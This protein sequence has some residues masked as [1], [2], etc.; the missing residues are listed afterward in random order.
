MNCNGSLSVTKP[1]ILTFS[2]CQSFINLSLLFEVRFNETPALTSGN[3][4]WASVLPSY[5]SVDVV[6]KI[7]WT[8]LENFISCKV[9]G[10]VCCDKKSISP[11]FLFN[12]LVGVLVFLLSRCEVKLWTY[13]TAV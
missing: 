10:L 12:S 6:A 1:R 4:S 9:S 5:H 8:W 2:M 13:Q 3:L 7:N 11:R